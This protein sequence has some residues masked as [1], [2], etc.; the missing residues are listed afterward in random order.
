MAG[1][2]TGANN[3]ECNPGSGTPDFLL[4]ASLPASLVPTRNITAG[5]FPSSEYSPTSS[6]PITGSATSTRSAP[7]VATATAFSRSASATSLKVAG[8]LSPNV[9]VGIRSAGM[10]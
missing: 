2:Y 3:A 7:R 4:S 6:D 10:P 8:A 9:T 5:I 1:A